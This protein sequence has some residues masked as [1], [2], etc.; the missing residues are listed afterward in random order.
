MVTEQQRKKYEELK[1]R[2]QK[3]VV[4][5][6]LSSLQCEDSNLKTPRT[7]TNSSDTSAYAPKSQ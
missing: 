4:T 1:L 6:K 2:R 5:R 7:A 3:A